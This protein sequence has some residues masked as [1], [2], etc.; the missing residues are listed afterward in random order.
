MPRRTRSPNSPN[1]FDVVFNA[2]I[3]VGRVVEAESQQHQEQL[4]E[5]V[6]PTTTTQRNPWSRLIGKYRDD[7]S[8]EEFDKFLIGYRKNIDRLY[9]QSKH[10]SK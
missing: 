3:F 7:R 4:T 1:V 8:W 10:S 5:T 6:A 9:A 2:G